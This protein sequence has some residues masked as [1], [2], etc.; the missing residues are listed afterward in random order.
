MIRVSVGRL[1]KRKTV[2][3][4]CGIGRAWFEQVTDKCKWVLHGEDPP[5]TRVKGV[6]GRQ[7]A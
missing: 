2:D 6:G 1:K 4:E 5:S 7:P 3:R